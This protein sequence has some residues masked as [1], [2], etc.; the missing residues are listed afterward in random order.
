MQSVYRETLSQLFQDVPLTS[1]VGHCKNKGIVL[2]E[3]EESPREDR[4]PERSKN[5]DVLTVAQMTWAHDA[6]VELRP[7]AADERVGDSGSRHGDWGRDKRDEHENTR[8]GVK[9]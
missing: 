3:V 6:G 1:D 7:E 4:K 8:G 2:R 5:E 9:G